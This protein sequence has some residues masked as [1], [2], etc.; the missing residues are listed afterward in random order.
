MPKYIGVILLVII[1][2]FSLSSAKEFG[3][4]S[5]GYKPVADPGRLTSLY[6]NPAGLGFNKGFG[7]LY[8]H[9]HNPQLFSRDKSFS[10]GVGN[11][12]FGLDYLGQSLPY[13]YRRYNLG[14]AESYKDMISFGIA[15]RWNRHSGNA[16][17]K[18]HQWDIGTILRPNKYISL[19]L[20]GESLNRPKSITGYIQP[21]YT[22]GFS[23]RPYSD[24]IT[25]SA[26]F[27][28]KDGDEFDEI[29]STIGFELQPAKGFTIGFEI[30]DHS[31]YG[32]NVEL[33]SLF[34]KSTG[35]YRANKDGD[36][37]KRI[38]EFEVSSKAY[39]G[40][41]LNS[42]RFL[43]IDISENI[44]EE[45]R[46]RGKLFNKNRSLLDILTMI[47]RASKDNSI[48]GILLELEGLKLGTASVQ[49]LRKHLI[50]FRK[51][52]KV[53]VAFGENISGR[54]YYLAASADKVYM[55]PSG[56]LNFS[57]IRAEVTYFKGLMDKL[58]LEAEIIATGEYKTAGE[59]VTNEEMS[60]A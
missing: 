23:I 43:K 28:A 15:Y 41:Q 10:I 59:I 48:S 33:T 1:N 55:V 17:G 30:S 57:G 24:F 6:H 46:S 42:G 29:G 2:L 7:F 27:S 60:D 25:L 5:I 39:P 4:Q 58:G 20:I 22:G 21:T 16:P 12:G 18:L 51:N 54:E 8:S 36:A 52:G 11:L 44:V 47:K 9:S 50:D 19:G 56:Y 35:Y 26:E 13:N 3:F 45:N 40:Y 49:E 38:A 32:F 31:R 34:S 53:V 14:F 37:L